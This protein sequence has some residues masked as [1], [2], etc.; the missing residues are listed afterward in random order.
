MPIKYSELDVS[1][2]K[3]T[4]LE[5]NPRVNAQKIGYVRYKISDNENDNE[6][7][8][9][10]QTPEIDTETY[11]IPRD[12]TYYE[13]A[14]K[15]AFYKLPFCHDR[16][17]FTDKVNY[18]Q[19]EVFYNKLIEIDKMCDNDNF[20]KQMFG[21]TLYSKYEY[22]PLIRFPDT[23]D[24]DGNLKL[25]KKGNPSYL[26]PY[27]KVKLELEYNQSS[28]DNNVEIS[29]KPQFIIFE[30]KDGKRNKLEL[31][32]FY[33]V[34]K[35]I[36]YRSKLKFIISFSKIYAMKVA[37]N[38][39]RQYGITLKATHIEVQK[40]VINHMSQNSDAFVDSDTEEI[41]EST[42]DNPKIGRSKNILDDDN[43]SN[44]NSE[45]N[46]YAVKSKDM[47]DVIEQSAENDDDSA[48]IIEEP[49]KEIK[50]NLVQNT[51]KTVQTKIEIEQF[52]NEDEE[53]NDVEVV[54][55]V[56]PSKKTATKGKSA[57]KTK[58]KTN[59]R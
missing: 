48:E 43:E 5:E 38:G 31:E 47:D 58:A 27:T 22:Q 16:R 15:R 45:E 8:L 17:K 37:K 2:I 28:S 56:K 18:D 7:N 1:R 14:H 12:G 29:T 33:D 39:K 24:D 42:Q 32:N 40:P 55:D 36:T 46:E 53:D 41:I 4:K 49:V 20:R 34:E 25:D 9:T 59:A 26:P 50:K 52:D 54:E 21:D 13:T 30:K 23:N 10:I 11:G 51:K 3:F 44:D 6:V 19:I 57:V 35:N